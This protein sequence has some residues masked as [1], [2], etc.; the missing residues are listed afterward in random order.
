M[1]YF[2]GLLFHGNHMARLK[3]QFLRERLQTALELQSGLQQPDRAESQSHHDALVAARIRDTAEFEDCVRDL[4]AAL[5]GR[6]LGRG[7]A[8][9]YPW[10]ETALQA[11]L[12]P[13]PDA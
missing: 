3:V 9:P 13:K 5:L 4:V 1:R 10:D 2:N 12:E 7:E 6:E 11:A 8:L